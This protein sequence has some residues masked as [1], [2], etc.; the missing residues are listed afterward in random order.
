MTAMVA[1]RKVELFEGDLPD[2]RF[3]HY[4]K[5]TYIAVD[6]ETRGL[7]IPRDRLCLV[8]ICDDEGIVEFRSL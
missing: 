8:Q 1:H 7:N 4:M 5:K 6:T 3:S 2:E